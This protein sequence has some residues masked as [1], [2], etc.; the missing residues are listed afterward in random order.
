MQTVRVFAAIAAT[1]LAYHWAVHAAVPERVGDFTLRV[2]TDDVPT[3]RQMAES[4][5]GVLFVGSFDAGRVY[6]VVP[7]EDG[8]PEVVIVDSGLRR[9]SGIVL[10][11]P[12]L[13]VAA[14]NRILR[15]ANISDG[16]R[17]SPEPTVVTD[18]LPAESHHGWKYL[19]FGPDGFLY[20]PVGAP[21]NICERTDDER[22]ATILRM[23]PD[24]GETTVYAQGVRNSVGMAW[25]E[26]T[27]ELWFSENGRDWLG[28]DLPAD[29][30]NRVTTPGAHYGYPYIHAGDVADPAFGQGKDPA[31]YVSPE[32]D[33][34]A[35]AA[36]LGVA[37][38][39]GNQFPVRYCGAMFVAEHGSWNRYSSKVGYQVSVLR[40]VNPHRPSGTGAVY[41]PFLGVWLSGEAHT[42]RPNDVLVSRDGSLL[43]SDDYAGAIYRVAYSPQDP[44][45]NA[46]TGCADT[47]HIAVFAP[48]S[49]ATREGFARVVNRGD[50]P[51]T[52]RMDAFDNPG[53]RYGPLTLTVGAGQ[54]AHF[55]STDLEDGNSAKGLAEGIGVGS[56][57]W[58]VELRSDDIDVL[59]YMR[60]EDGFVTSLH[61]VA[62]LLEPVVVAADGQ[63]LE[64]R[65]RVP[66]FNPGSNPN[67]KSW[68]RLVNAGEATAHI[69][70]TGIDDQ[71]SPSADDVRLDLAGGTSRTVSAEDLEAGTD[72]DGALGDGS[73]K[74][75]LVVRSDRPILVASLLESP[76]GHM[77]NLSTVPDN[78]APGEAGETVH[79][80]P[81]F[82]SAG[83]SDARQGF[84]RIANRSDEAG[85]VLIKAQNDTGQDYPALSLALPA[86]WTTHFNSNDLEMGDASKGLPTGVGPGQGDWRL[87]LT[88]ALDLDV[89]AYIRRT[90]DGFLTSMHDFVQPGG[91]GSYLVPFF[92]PARNTDQVS[93]LLIQNHT[94]QPA[95]ITIEGI[96]DHGV[97]PADTVQFRLAAG[98]TRTLSAQALET[99]SDDVSGALGTGAGKWRL[100]V[101]SDQLLD[102][103]NL[104]ESP[105]GHLTNLSTEPGPVNVGS[106]V[107]QEQ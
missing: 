56:G 60:T 15:Y 67:Q 48:A 28:D 100:I 44:D 39:Q 38:Y 74:W 77:T 58:R 37:F 97:S 72:L 86:N 50:A 75:R 95:E 41:E 21:C 20:V 27:G 4:P 90:S 13:Y 88:S 80:V 105:T 19:V 104:L 84:V 102:V 98:A 101:Q 8:E 92:N 3:A 73:G 47:G 57:D 68:L 45:L 59:A 54:V 93:R 2:V 107:P 78:K 6:A 94:D 34:Q 69:E 66:I 82:P 62:P 55:N 36:T 96:D 81:L 61:D 12:D 32:V 106:S 51:A 26:R 83:D 89:F 63:S 22:F 33:V 53:Q 9:P 64:H 10:R 103:V 1:A 25:H 65:Y 7:V 87:E 91:D 40:F 16:F 14:M 18:S 99:G 5:D 76:T 30:I 49:H 35:H 42:G 43:I 79:R 46:I 70:I 71:G 24:T 31:D 23:D 52:I 29:E 85:S 11:G 17:N